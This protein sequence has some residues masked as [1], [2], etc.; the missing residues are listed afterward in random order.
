VVAAVSQAANAESS[1]LVGSS[2][3][4]DVPLL[5]DGDDVTVVAPSSNHLSCRPHSLPAGGDSTTVDHYSAFISLQNIFCFLFGRWEWT[6][7]NFLQKFLQV[8]GAP[9]W[10]LLSLSVPV[11][12]YDEASGRLTGLCFAAYLTNFCVMPVA[13]VVLLGMPLQL[14][15]SQLPAVMVA[16]VVA[17]I[18]FALLLAADHLDLLRDNVVAT[19]PFFGFGMSVLWIYTLANE[20]VGVL[21][22]SGI[23]LNIND[24]S[25]GLTVLAWGNSIGDLVTNAALGG[26]HD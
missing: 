11:V 4:D 26:C 18:V 20:I 1:V 2:V 12:E 5:N 16:L 13:I 17:S 10:C 9:L 22:S 19:F 21:H 3:N 6:D 15:A 24:A 23:V 8:F 7:L 25:L 14:V